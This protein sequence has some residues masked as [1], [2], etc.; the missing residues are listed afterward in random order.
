MGSSR[1]EYDGAFHMWLIPLLVFGVLVYAVARSPREAP[2]PHAL[3]PGPTS[4]ISVLGEFLRVGQTPPPPVILC[5]VAEAEAIGRCDLASDIVRAFVAPVVYQHVMESTG[6]TGLVPAITSH[7]AYARGACFLQPHTPRSPREIA[8]AR[9]PLPAATPPAL[10]QRAV[11]APLIPQSH[12]VPPSNEEIQAMLNADPQG[13]FAAVLHG[14]GSPIVDVPAKEVPPPAAPPEATA[15]PAPTDAAA[16]AFVTEAVSAQL[17]Q[18]PGFS[19]AGVVRD[20]ATNADFFEVRWLRGFPVPQL[21]PQAGTWPVRVVIDDA[22]PVAQPSPTG[23]H[24]ETVAQMQ[25][26]AGL[27][28]AADRTRALAP[29]SPIGGISDDAW[30]T[31][32]KRLE[33]E[34]P[35]FSSSRH[36]GQYRQRRERLAELGIDLAAIANSAQA[37][38]AALDVDLADAH[39]HAV[40]GGLVDYLGKPFVVPGQEGAAALT[41]SGLL[42]VIQCAGLDGATSWLER[43]GDRKKFPHTT[44]AFLNTNGIY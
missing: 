4:P 35:S 18:L 25:E 15:S 5:A 3:G 17:S 27:A 36:V 20:L 31:F 44:Q 26:A 10:P 41:L 13:F 28:E 30:R 6:G 38:R 16:E 23:M 32:V 2:P 8:D 40:N 9:S 12:P 21:P 24:P 7:P 34:A 39:A 14:S 22:L 1:A 29:G 19:G 11:P 42:G 37:Q 33:R 43:S